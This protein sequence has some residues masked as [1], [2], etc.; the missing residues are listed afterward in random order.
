[1]RTE[2]RV[3]ESAVSGTLRAVPIAML[4]ADAYPARAAVLRI[5]T[6]YSGRR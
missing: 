1:M 6:R 5:A 2:L 3:P 4:S